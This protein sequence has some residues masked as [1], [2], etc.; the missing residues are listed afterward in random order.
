[1][2]KVASDVSGWC[3]KTALPWTHYYYRCHSVL[4]MAQVSQGR[5]SQPLTYHIPRLQS[6]P[7]TQWMVLL[8]PPGQSLLCQKLAQ[9]VFGWSPNQ[10]F[11]GPIS[12]GKVHLPWL[13]SVKEGPYTL[14]GSHSKPSSTSSHTMDGPSSTSRGHFCAKSELKMCLA[15]PQISP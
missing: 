2:P 14:V 10:P 8:P 9:D 4:T 1:M 11:T 12:D 13:R 7:G 15:G 3:P 6:L 5:P